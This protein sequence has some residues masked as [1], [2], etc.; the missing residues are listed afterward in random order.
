MQKFTYDHLWRNFI[1]N[2]LDF[3]KAVLPYPVYT[4]CAQLYFFKGW[5]CGG[6]LTVVLSPQGG[7][8]ACEVSLCQVATTLP[9]EPLVEQGIPSGAQTQSNLPTQ[10]ASL[11]GQSNLHS[12]QI[13]LL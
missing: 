11:C 1:Y 13:K 5:Y 8:L 10:S 12:A 7:Y 9:N 3:H 2:C 6:E 4:R